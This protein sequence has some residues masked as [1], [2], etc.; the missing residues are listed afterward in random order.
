MDTPKDINLI[1]AAQRDDQHALTALYRKYVDSVYKFIYYRTGNREEAEDLTSE[2]F[3]KMMK[4]LKSFSFDSTFKTWLLGIAKHTVLDYF[5]KYYKNRTIPL[6][7][8]LNIDLGTLDKPQEIDKSKIERLSH[9]LKKLP[10]NYRDVLELRFL[11]G[12]SIKETALELDK[13]ISNI[14]VM[15]Y[16][17]L[18]KAREL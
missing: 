10:K 4:S 8:F 16:R 7:N 14:K 2:T 9:L 13:T 17:A 11:R 1:L 5:R 12:Y 6:E 3:I 18:Q 15:Q